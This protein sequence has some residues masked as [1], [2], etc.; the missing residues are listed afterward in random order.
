MKS[1][2][3]EEIKE[4]KISVIIPVLNGYGYLPYQIRSIQNQNMDEIEIIIV[5]DNS[6]DKKIEV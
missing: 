4:V 3:K 6:K 5:D 1:I 2:P